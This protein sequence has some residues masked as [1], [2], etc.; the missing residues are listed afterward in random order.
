MLYVETLQESRLR[1][2]G[3]EAPRH[4]VGRRRRSARAR[5]PSSTTFPIELMAKVLQ[6]LVQRG[7]LTSH[8][9]TRGGYKLSKP[10][11]VDLGRRHHPGDRRSADRDRL[12]DRGRAVRAV[13]QVQR[14]RSAVADQGPHP[15]GAGHVLARRDR[16]PRAP[17]DETVMPVSLTRGRARPSVATSRDRR[18]PSTSTITRRRRSIR[19]CSRRCCRTSPSSSAIRTAGSMP[20]DGRRAVRSTRRA[21]GSPRSSTPA[22]ARFCSPAAPANPTTSP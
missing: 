2:D 21:S 20:G 13:R 4:Q 3:D 11:A 22:R 12:L 18:S 17:L 9:G 6:R 16:R 1:A 19:A 10:T 8:Q 5:S 7:L 14:P 15:R